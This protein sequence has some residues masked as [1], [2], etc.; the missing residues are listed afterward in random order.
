MIATVL[1]A[2]IQAGQLRGTDIP[3]L[4]ALG[5]HAAHASDRAR[6]SK[7]TLHDLLTMRTG[8]E[9]H[10][11]DRPLDGTNTTVQLEASADWVRFTLEQP[12][13]ADPRT[14]WAYNSGGSHLIGAVIQ[15]ATGRSPADVARE[16]LFGPLGIREFHWKPTG[17]GLPDGEGGLFLSAESLAKVG[18]LYLRDGLWGDR[19]IL[20]EGW[21]RE[22][23]G[24][25]VTEGIPGGRSY[26]LQWWRLDRDG[27]EIWAG[28]GF[29]GQYLLVYPQL[30]LIVVAFGWNIF[31]DR[32]QPILPAVFEAV[33]TSVRP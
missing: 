14:K 6:L 28:L 3:L 30:D 2:T 7:A 23:T 24:K 20:P 29:G 26:G 16:L 15:Q 17:G 19:R 11:G 9:W 13:D 25:L 5:P 27:Q 32:V 31:G 18:L 12:M 4:D 8:I 21:V 33:R 1:G 10:E 22:A